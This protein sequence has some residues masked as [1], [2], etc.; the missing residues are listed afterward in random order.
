M[1]LCITTLAVT[2]IVEE[3]EA[4]LLKETERDP[5]NQGKE[6]QTMGNRRKDVITCLQILGDHE[7]L[8]TTPQSVCSVANQAAAKAMLSRS[9]LTSSGYYE[10]ISVNDMPINCSKSLISF[11]LCNLE[12][13]R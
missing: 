7:A 10:S 2:N 8:L 3:E 9:G 1:L 6:T 12:V 5:A 4:E 13:K 11:H